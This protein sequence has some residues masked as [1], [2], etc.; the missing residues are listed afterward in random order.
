M[1][2]RKVNLVTGATS[3]IAMQL[4]KR[5]LAQGEEVR[6]LVVRTDLSTRDTLALPAGT[7]PYVCDLTLTSKNDANVLE[8]ACR[9]V[10]RI[11]HIA[12]ATFN[13]LFT[14]NQLININVA[15]TEN[16][17]QAYLNAN[18]KSAASV[19]F[20]FTS[21]IT[22]Y[23]Y[24]RKGEQLTESSLLKP[25]SN[26]SESKLMAER[27]IEAFAEAHPRIKYTI[28]RLGTLYGTGYERS[29]LKVFRLIKE[30]K[31]AYIGNGTNHL[32]LLNVEDAA[33]A[34][35]LAAESAKSSNNIYNITDGVPY[36]VRQLMSIAADSL[37]APQPTR[38]IPVLVAKLARKIVNV[39]YDEFEFLASDR[40]VKIDKAMKELKFKPKRSMEQE[41]ARL[42]PIFEKSAVK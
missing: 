27:L 4:I 37:N 33:D 11:F 18:S 41:G 17:L 25:A 28:L 39:N 40:I 12:G 14:F 3:S 38:K 16:L 32:T 23:G 15:G 20:L 35:V 2:D 7:K 31:M 42:V 8:D 5:L 13:A 6:S 22:V 24:R 9:G 21:S 30:G 36:T 19:Q 1:M 26:Y 34:L 29:Y 10:D